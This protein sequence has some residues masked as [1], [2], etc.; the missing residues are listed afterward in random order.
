MKKATVFFVIFLLTLVHGLALG[1]NVLYD[2]FSGESLDAEKW[3]G[4]SN[5]EDPII[6]NGAL[7]LA[8]SGN[9]SKLTNNLNFIQNRAIISIQTKVKI[10]NESYVSSG[11]SGKFRIGAMCY[12]DSHGP[13]SG[14]SY[15]QNEGN[16]WADFRL[17]LD[18][19]HTL[20]AVA[21]ISRINDAEDTSETTLFYKEFNTI[22]NFDTEYT[23]SMGVEDGIF[24]LTLGSETY[25]YAIETPMYIPY[26]G[27]QMVTSRLY[28]DQGEQGLFKAI[29]DDVMV[30]YDES[31]NTF[32]VGSIVNSRWGTGSDYNTWATIEVFKANESFKE[33]IESIT[34]TTPSGET[35]PYTKDDFEFFDYGSSFEYGI[36]DIPGQPEI[37][38]YTFTIVANGVTYTGTDTQYQNRELPIPDISAFHIDGQTFSW[39]L[40]DYEEDIPLYY[41]FRLY[42]ANGNRLVN[43]GHIQDMNSFTFEYGQLTMGEA[44]R[45]YVRVSDS[46]DWYQVQNNAYSQKTFTFEPSRSI[47][48]TVSGDDDNNPDTPD[49]PVAGNAYSGFFRCLQLDSDWLGKYRYQWKLY[50]QWLT[51]WNGCLR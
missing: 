21:D 38:T 17:V 45:M 42:D 28:L 34:I 5:N 23:M 29:L 39:D 49:V 12:N 14:Q 44:Y 9:D 31:D 27:G 51:R 1:N 3:S 47:S 33:N 25:S 36:Y 16:V 24:V 11:A 20:K 40:V 18:D 43:T 10:A 13:G 15:N 41:R 30:T 19:S 2:D 26:N 4:Y 7:E 50:G 48:G 32:L 22:I 37:G 6:V 46:D 35:L 8:I